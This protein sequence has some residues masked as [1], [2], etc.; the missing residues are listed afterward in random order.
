MYLFN[1]KPSF[2]QFVVIKTNYLLKNII[3][4]SLF[5]EKNLSLPIC[6]HE[7]SVGNYDSV[8]FMVLLVEKKLILILRFQK[9]QL[10]SA[11]FRC[12]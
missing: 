3:N 9:F 1:W 2:C 7:L 4:R 8:K 6:A 5:G 12:E 10:N 11:Q